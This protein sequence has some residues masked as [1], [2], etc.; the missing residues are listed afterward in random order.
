VLSLGLFGYPGGGV[1]CD[2]D[3]EAELAD[4]ADFALAAG[5]V[6]SAEP[7]CG[8]IWARAVSFSLLGAHVLGSATLRAQMT[9]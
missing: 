5:V 2:V 1:L 7:S 3:C 8:F 6:A 4:D 9:R